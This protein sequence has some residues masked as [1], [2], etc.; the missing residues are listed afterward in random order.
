MAFLSDSDIM[1][2]VSYP[3]NNILKKI[4]KACYFINNF[5]YL[6]KIVLQNNRKNINF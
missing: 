5:K 6:K 4:N 1:W 2:I 3:E